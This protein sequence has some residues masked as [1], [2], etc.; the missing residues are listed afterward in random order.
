MF[1]FT[2][3]SIKYSCLKNCWG[4]MDGLKLLLKRSCDE[5]IQNMFYNG[6]THDHYVPQ[7]WCP[8]SLGEE[9]SSMMSP[10][11]LPNACL[12]RVLCNSACMPAIAA[13]TPP[14]W[15]VN[16]RLFSLSTLLSPSSAAFD[17]RMRLCVDW[18][19]WAADEDWGRWAADEDCLA[20][21][22]CNACAACNCTMHGDHLGDGPDDLPD[23]LG[24]DGLAICCL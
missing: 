24:V 9:S 20:C 21:A 4:A 1:L 8:C 10:A 17:W 3:S 5:M 19:C 23:E 12:W 7:S 18:G 14:V 6:W 13:L 16:W 11:T 2:S 15:E 22:D